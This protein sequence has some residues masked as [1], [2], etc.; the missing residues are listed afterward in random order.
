MWARSLD[1]EDPLEEGLA[2]HSSILAC[3]IPRTEEP[4]GLQFTGSQSVSPNRVTN[5]HD[6]AANTG[7]FLFLCVFF[8]SLSTRTES[9]RVFSIKQSILVSQQIVES[10]ALLPYSALHCMCIVNRTGTIILV[11]LP[12]Q[13]LPCLKSLLPHIAS[14]SAQRLQ[15]QELWTQ[16]PMGAR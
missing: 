6:W 7:C 12:S 11:F 14:S 3:R 13:L 5:A 10:C 9:Q 1:G 15:I 16:G 4:G 8:T 2:T